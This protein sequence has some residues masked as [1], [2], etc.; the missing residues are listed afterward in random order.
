[1]YEFYTYLFPI[2]SIIIFLVLRYFIFSKQY[3]NLQNLD[4]LIF[5]EFNRDLKKNDYQRDD[6]INLQ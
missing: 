6:S 1:M 4:V 2:K 3:E 5:Y